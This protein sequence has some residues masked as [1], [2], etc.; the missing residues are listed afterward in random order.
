MTVCIAAM[1]FDKQI[2]AVS[3]EMLSGAT[4]SL[5]AVF[6]G[7]GIGDGWYAMFSASD[8]SRI[9]DLLE[10]VRSAFSGASVTVA[11]TKLEG[12][13][14]SV[15][16]KE[17]TDNVLSR[18]NITLAEFRTDGWN[19]F[20]KAEFSRMKELVDNY[21]LGIDLL[22]CG[23]DSSGDPHIVHVT[24]PGRAIIR[25]LTNAWAIGSGAWTA[26]GSLFRH[27]KLHVSRLDELLYRMCEAKFLS[28]NARGVGKETDI[29]II[30]QGWNI[31]LVDSDTLKKAREA[32]DKQTNCPVPDEAAEAIRG[33]LGKRTKPQT[34]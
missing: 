15:L 17:I 30:E 5:D 27:K 20:G 13:Y 14:Q 31:S 10:T 23:H 4:F 29:F 6:K 26:L 12:A 7:E 22:V 24:D 9:P 18:W 34:S 28:E 11:A 1:N 33:F 19:N 2:V 21:K 25:D 32:F 8:V 16:R 3:D